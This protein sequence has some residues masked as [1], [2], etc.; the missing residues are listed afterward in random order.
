MAEIIIVS[1]PTRKTHFLTPLSSCIGERPLGGSR[2]RT[3]SSH[4]YRPQS[5]SRIPCKTGSSTACPVN[6]ASS[7]SSGR[8]PANAA[9]RARCEAVKTA[10]TQPWTEPSCYPF[11]SQQN[12]KSFDRVRLL[13][14]VLHVSAGPKTRADGGP[15]RIEEQ[16][17]VIDVDQVCSALLPC[18]DLCRPAMSRA[19]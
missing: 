19:G 11:C 18:R 5:V 14:T 3:D 15:R 17:D 13:R 7:V 12:C 1:V 6:I 2:S 8:L 9:L 16:D 10:L 4:R